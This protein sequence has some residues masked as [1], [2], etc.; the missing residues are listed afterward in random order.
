MIYHDKKLYISVFLHNDIIVKHYDNS[1]ADYFNYNKTLELLTR[2]Y[3]W[4]CIAS[5]VKEYIETC[6]ICRQSKALR[7]KSY[8]QLASLS[9]SIELWSNII[10]DFIV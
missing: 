6:A 5:E 4:L 3:S 2:K 7:H 9:L 10:I 8:D 1:L